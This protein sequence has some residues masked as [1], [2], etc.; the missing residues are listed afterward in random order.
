[1]SKKQKLTPWFSLADNPSRPG[2]YEIKCRDWAGPCF[3]RFNGQRWNGGF[4]SPEKAASARELWDWLNPI[5]VPTAKWRGLA[6]NPAPGAAQE[7]TP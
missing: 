7:T 1:M 5:N 6:E 3:S 2:V 4:S